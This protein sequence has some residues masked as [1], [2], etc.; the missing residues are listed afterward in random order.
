M[1]VFAQSRKGDNMELQ[2][3][4]IVDISKTLERFFGCSGKMVKPCPTTVEAL[5]QKIPQ[6]KLITI[7]L[8][9]K[10]L[11]DQF[12]VEIACPFD[13][14]IALRAIANDVS[15]KVPYWRVVKTNGELIAYF[16][17]GREGHAALLRE[18]GFTIDLKGETLKVK[19]FKES[20][21]E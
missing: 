18:E 3:D 7:E 4:I 16:P 1:V 11:A 12:N 13:T 15:K 19:N 6:N 5:I 2:E 21:V 9:R 17:G 8:L 14:K 10:K 20:L